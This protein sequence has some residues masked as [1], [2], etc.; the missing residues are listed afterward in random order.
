MRAQ[1]ISLLG[2]LLHVDVNTLDGL[3]VQKKKKQNKGG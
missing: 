1:K 3:Q 2:W